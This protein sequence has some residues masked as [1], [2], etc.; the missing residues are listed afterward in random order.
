MT[1][2][3]FLTPPVPQ[4][5]FHEADLF[6]SLHGVLLQLWL[7]WELLLVGEP[8][9]VIA[10]TPTQCSEA[11]AA[12]VG[13]IAPLPISMDFRP[14]FTIHDPQFP[15]LNALRDGDSVPPV[16]LGVTNLFFLKAL[17]TLP[18]VLSVGRPPHG[19]Q[20]VGGASRY[21]GGSGGIVHPNSQVAARPAPARL[22]VPSP[23]SSFRR[24]AA[25]SIM[26]WAC[27][28]E[29][30]LVRACRAR[31]CWCSVSV[32]VISSGSTWACPL[33]RP[34]L[35]PAICVVGGLRVIHFVPLLRFLAMFSLVLALQC[36]LGRDKK[37]RPHSQGGPPLSDVGTQGGTVDQLQSCAAPGHP[38]A[39][40]PC[41]QRG[42][43]CSW[44][45]WHLGRPT[46]RGWGR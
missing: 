43:S 18:N 21:Q 40:L 28:K 25:H 5:I 22:S 23:S 45:R 20:G 12:L 36:F 39:Q 33:A 38:S 41:G 13:L 16:L 19:G 10:P 34:P 46:C 3:C 26:R 27:L 15:A 32:S 30:S 6:S 8:L 44:G 35:S 1:P 29:D 11:I 7:L 14:Y 31:S 37:P 24:L 17:K 42:R 4:G 2:V 9:L